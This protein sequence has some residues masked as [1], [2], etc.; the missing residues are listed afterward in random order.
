MTAED[1]RVIF[2][3]IVELAHFSDTFS[4][5]LE[6]ALGS[7]IEG[8]IGEDSVGKLFLEIIPILER[9]YK[10]YITRQSSAR[11]TPP[12]PSQTP[13]LS[14][15]FEQTRAYSTSVSHAWDLHSLL[16][17]PVQR[18]LKYPLLLSAIIEATPETH[19]DLA[20]LKKAKESVEVI[21]R[22]V[23]EERRRAE[24][25][26][27]VL[28]GS[29]GAHGSKMRKG[30]GI[31]IG[32][33]TSVNLGK[34]KSLKRNAGSGGI[35][36]D[37]TG[38]PVELEGGGTILA[39]PSSTSSSSSLQGPSSAEAQKVEKL[40]G[41]LK[42]IEVFAQQFAKNI[43]DWGKAASAVTY[44][45][46]GWAFAFSRVIGLGGGESQL[47]SEAFDAFLGVIEGVLVPPVSPPPEG[48]ENVHPQTHDGG[49]LGLSADLESQ[50]NEILYKDLAQLL[51]TLAQPVKLIRTMQHTEPYHYHLLNMT[52]SHKNRPPAALLETSESYLALRGQLAKELP[53]YIRLLSR[54]ME[55]VVRKFGGI[56]VAYWAG[57][58]DRW[59]E[60]WEMLRVEGEMNGGG[61]ETIGVWRQRWGDVDEGVRGLGV[62]S[63]RGGFKYVS[64]RKEDRDERVGE[65]VN[66][67]EEPWK[68][69]EKEKEK[70]EKKDKKEKKEKEKSPPPMKR[71][72][73]NAV[74]SV[75]ASLEP[76]HN[77]ISQPYPLSPSTSSLSSSRRARGL[78]DASMATTNT[79]N[80]SSS[81]RTGKR[82]STDSHRHPLPAS[83]TPQRPRADDWDELFPPP[84]IMGFGNSFSLPRTRSMPLPK[85]TPQTQT[86]TQGQGQGERYAFG[87]PKVDTSPVVP[88]EELFFR[89]ERE[90]KERGRLGRKGSL[91]RRVEDTFGGMGTG[92]PRSISRGDAPMPLPTPTP[93]TTATAPRPT[94]SKGRA[95]LP[96]NMGSSH[97]PP[98][99]TPTPTTTTT[100]NHQHT[101]SLT[102]TRST[103]VQS[104]TT[105][106]QTS[107]QQQAESWSTA[108]TKYTCVVIHP[109]RPPA[110][111]SYHGF[112]FFTL[113]EGDRFEVL[114]EAGHPGLHRK[115]P[116]YVDDGEDCLLLCRR[117]SRSEA[118]REVGWALASF[119]EPVEGWG[120][121]DG[122]VSSLFA[123]L[124]PLS[125]YIC[126]IVVDVLFPFWTCV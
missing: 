113:G 63:G 108:P 118:K 36:G 6:K 13:A 4:N 43:M 91:K 72:T 32:V 67:R 68:E 111:V 106:F 1:A 65:F 20:N 37:L 31:G 21:A 100:Y 121:G 40:A 69:K 41:E 44:N 47:E 81:G 14:S 42:R 56:Q 7:T 90:D 17:K 55:G 75:L 99:Y 82:E 73:S 70:K 2:N 49:L 23:N 86:Q 78:S 19:T 60:L 122:S 114:H 38:E 10:T 45:L 85:Q 88:V 64:G 89:S 18:L 109:C 110:P 16:I 66:V 94:S 27:G 112:P 34:M 96:A 107:S 71:T 125:L 15:Y 102:S 25:V 48:S 29:D 124:L 26:R 76:T 119:L 39:P 46:R 3:N 79:S 9:P 11:R 61:E 126:G 84:V 116:L 5:Q 12:E 62:V 92:A 93:T 117:V 54:G 24:V 35:L 53:V 123:L 105:R 95:S 30:S 22:N 52:V 50:I 87:L 59:G 74:A 28:M 97:G 103:P 58:R 77:N 115:L 120:L 101:P 80:T 51:S 33:A 104:S 57:V 98:A 83:H 8:G